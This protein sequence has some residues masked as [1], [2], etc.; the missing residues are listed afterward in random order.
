MK[1]LLILFFLLLGLTSSAKNTHVKT[2]TLMKSMNVSLLLDNGFALPSFSISGDIFLLKDH[3]IF[4]PRPYHGKRYEM[5]NDM[6]H[7]IKIPYDSILSAKKNSKIFGGL[8]IT[9]KSKK[10]KIEIASS[11]KKL[12]NKR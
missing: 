4:H 1:A 5:F 8:L 2:D 11:I 10:Y 3:F 12:G 7:D 6:V 9:T